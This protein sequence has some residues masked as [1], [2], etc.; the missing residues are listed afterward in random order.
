MGKRRVHASTSRVDGRCEEGQHPR[1]FDNSASS[2][3]RPKRGR[4]T[5]IAAVLPPEGTELGF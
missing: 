2:P 3:R 5:T 4:S 1:R